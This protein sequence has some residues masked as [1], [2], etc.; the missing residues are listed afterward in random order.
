IHPED[1][2]A[3]I[4][5]W[6]AFLKREGRYAREFRLLLPGQVLKHVALQAAPL[7]DEA[8]KTI[9]FVGAAEDITARRTSEDQQKR[10]TAILETTTDYIATSDLEGHVL[11]QNGALRKLL[12]IDEND[13]AN[14]LGEK[15]VKEAF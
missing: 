3:M 5:S 7:K 10:L 12:G 8:G 15:R 6:K 13:E 11:Y 9:G 2:R 4:G 1:R 14:L